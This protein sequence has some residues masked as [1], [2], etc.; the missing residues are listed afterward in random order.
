MIIISKFYNFY[1]GR[2]NRIRTLLFRQ[3]IGN[4]GSVSVYGHIDVINP[5]NIVVGN[6]CT[7]N[8]GC[9]L[10][11]FNPI[12]IGNDVTLS[13]NVSIISTGINVTNWMDG[14]KCH[15]KNDGVL[16]SDHVW[17]GAGAQILS[18]VHIK[19]K[20]VVIAAGS[21]VT[22]DIEE[23]YCLVGGCPAKLIKYFK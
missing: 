17:I 6:N 2:I 4:C 8:H 20:Y 19:G 5:R 16:I 3:I 9:Y 21:V 11:A 7:I 12:N 13:A 1:N 14:E 22:K 15:V 10:N 18:N 23:S